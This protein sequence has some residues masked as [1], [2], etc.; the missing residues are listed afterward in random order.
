MKRPADFPVAA[1][2]HPP[3]R[4]PLR[5]PEAV[6]G[7]HPLNSKEARTTSVTPVFIR[8]QTCRDELSPGIQA[9]WPA[10]AHPVPG[11][12]ELSA[13]LTFALPPM[14]SS[15]AR[16]WATARAVPL[17]TD[18]SSAY[19]CHL[20]APF[21]PWSCHSLLHRQNQCFLQFSFC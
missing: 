7:K 4:L 20:N 21:S 19:Q 15:L 1:V 2:C 18:C 14:C 10:G 17:P 8:T 9:T 13:H 6:W 16:P 5:K 3:C 12:S 11:P